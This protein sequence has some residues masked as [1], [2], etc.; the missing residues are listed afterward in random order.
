ML[1]REKGRF[2]DV[3]GFGKERRGIGRWRGALAV[4]GERW[5]ER[6]SVRGR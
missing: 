5:R 4:V 6:G 1:R 3:L 2:L